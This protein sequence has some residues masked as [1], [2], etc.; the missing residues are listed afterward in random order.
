[1]QNP[2]APLFLVMGVPR[3]GTTALADALNRH[4]AIFCGIERFDWPLE[5]AVYPFCIDDFFDPQ[6]PDAKF[7]ERNLAIVQPKTELVALGNKKPRYYISLPSL[8]QRQPARLIWTYRNPAHTAFSW[9]ARALNTE[10]AGWHRGMTGLYALVEFTQML[11][12]FRN[13]PEGTE[14]LMVDYNGLFLGKGIRTTL[15]SL[16]DFLQAGSDEKALSEFEQRQ[17]R[18][19]DYLTNKQRELYDFEQSFY[20][21]HGLG[22]L[23]SIMTELKTATPQQLRPQIDS[24]LLRLAQSKFL[25]DF[26]LNISRYPDSPAAEFLPNYLSGLFANADNATVFTVLG[27]SLNKQH[28]QLVNAIHE[29]SRIQCANGD[30]A[31]AV[32]R[33]AHQAVTRHPDNPSLH[34]SLGDQLTR[35]HRFQEAAE[36]FKRASKLAPYDMA[37][38]TGM[39][40]A[41]TLLQ[42]NTK[43]RQDHHEPR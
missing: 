26:F 17:E 38:R 7:H 6:V 32:L 18:F 29:H 2:E 4:P 42:A 35:M 27:Q 21:R 3:S 8:L 14:A 20:D 12:T 40:Q 41:L 9:N 11:L 24:F 30:V 37:A 13:L 28:R 23:D 39:V 10:D 16:F 25:N 15:S 19:A 31:K 33:H 34:K 43:H 1:M 36:A 22:E 5:K